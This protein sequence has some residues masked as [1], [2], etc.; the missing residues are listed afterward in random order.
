MSGRKNVLSIYKIIDA[1]DMSQSS[2]TS[3]VTNITYLDNVCIEL[4]FTGSPVGTFSVQ[5]SLDHQQDALG[6]IITAGNWVSLTLSPA[7]VA[8]G[9]A[10]Q[11]VIDLNQLSFPYIRVVYTK[12]SGTGTLNGWIGAKML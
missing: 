6:N 1:G 3:A 12:T 4:V 9:S 10:D 2:I 7:P 8:S 11:I 5:G